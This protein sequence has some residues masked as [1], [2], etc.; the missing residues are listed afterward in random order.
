MATVIQIRLSLSNLILGE[1][2]VRVDIGRFLDDDTILR[3]LAKQG[4][5]VFARA[6]CCSY[7]Q[8]FDTAS[9]RDGRCSE[10]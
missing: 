7:G 10:L 2:P 8:Q 1:H 9:G 3:T 5:Q 4:S 6:S